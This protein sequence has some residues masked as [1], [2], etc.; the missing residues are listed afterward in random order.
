ML[1]VLILTHSQPRHFTPDH[2]RL[3]EAAA[4]Q[5]ALA[6]RNARLFEVQRRMAERQTT[7]YEV[8]RAV[9][10]QLNADVIAQTAVEAIAHFAGWPHVALLLADSD[11]QHWMV[12]A[13]SGAPSLPLGF[14]L[15]IAPE[16]CAQ[17]CLQGCD[18]RRRCRHAWSDRSGRAAPDVAHLVVPLW[19]GGSLIGI[20]NIEGTDTIVFDADD[21]SLAQS[22]A[23]AVALALDNARLY[24]YINDERSRLQASIRF[25][26]DGIAL[27]G[28]TQ[29]ILVIN[30]QA[31]RLLELPGEPEDWLNRTDQR[32]DSSAAPAESRGRQSASSARS[33]AFDAATSRRPKASMKSRRA[34]CIGPACPC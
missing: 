29:R 30:A 4:D 15:P 6:V 8:L 25:N 1:G 10:G 26:R 11:T 19:Q 20:L 5:M 23:D 33:G 32:C 9:S 17:R 7:L 3:M 28:M 22:L 18:S 2:V 34:W 27:L 21:L 13:V 31:L 24:E 14:S 16:I 12:R